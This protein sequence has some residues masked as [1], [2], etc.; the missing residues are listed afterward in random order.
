MPA[1][2]PYVATAAA[3][4]AGNKLSG[5]GGGNGNGSNGGGS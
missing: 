5:G 4:W 1:A 3:T 2:I